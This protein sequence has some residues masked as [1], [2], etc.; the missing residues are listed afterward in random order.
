[1]PDR[2]VTHTTRSPAPA[3]AR[4]ERRLLD[5]PDLPC[6][7]SSQTAN[8]TEERPPPALRGMSPLPRRPCGQSPATTDSRHGQSRL[9]HRSTL[10]RWLQTTSR[11]SF[12]RRSSRRPPD[13]A[14][15]DARDPATADEG[16]RQGPRR[17]VRSHPKASGPRG[18]LD[19]SAG[20]R[21]PG[22]PR[23]SAPLR[24]A[25]PT[26]SAHAI[27][28][29]GDGRARSARAAPLHPP[30]YHRTRLVY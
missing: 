5:L 6:P 17:A 16:A 13:R 14:A 30:R 18:P 20:R 7:S 15:P 8:V 19:A 26:A 1:M 4:T 3:V 11:H 24:D 2:R 25:S 12:A 28:R 27:A 29:G 22:S 10:P 21:C 9:R 23:R